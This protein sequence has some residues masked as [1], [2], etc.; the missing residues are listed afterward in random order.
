MAINAYTRQQTA[1]L[2]RLMRQLNEQARERAVAVH[3]AGHAVIHHILGIRV[4]RATI[5]PRG[6]YNGR[7]SVTRPYDRTYGDALPE[8]ILGTFAGYW[9]EKLLADYPQE[10]WMLLGGCMSDRIQIAG[11][12]DG[13]LQEG[14]LAAYDCALKLRKELKE[15]SR[16]LVLERQTALLTFA[17]RLFVARKME[18]DEVREMLQRLTGARHVGTIF[19]SPILTACRDRVR[20]NGGAA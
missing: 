16:M 11:A 4:N 12:L 10:E 3:E 6:D 13:L 8:Y 18:R 5:I 1:E 15:V 20:E 9:A 2:R 7:V 19:P 14:R 17:E